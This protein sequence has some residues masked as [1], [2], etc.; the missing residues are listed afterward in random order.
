M[1]ISHF[2][3]SKRIN[4]I[5]AKPLKPPLFGLSLTHHQSHYH[6][7]QWYLYLDVLLK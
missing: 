3:L 2:K 4:K 6:N 1:K 7:R 5:T